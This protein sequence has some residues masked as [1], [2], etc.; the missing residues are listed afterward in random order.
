MSLKMPY[1]ELPSKPPRHVSP[2]EW[3]WL[4][5]IIRQLAYDE[6]MQSQREIWLWQRPPKRRAAQQADAD[7]TVL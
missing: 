4:E 2:E 7:T 1:D 6:Y 3:K 5:G